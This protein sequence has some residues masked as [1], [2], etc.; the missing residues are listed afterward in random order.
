VLAVNK[1]KLRSVLLSNQAMPFDGL[2]W[3]DPPRT[4]GLP[5]TQTGVQTGGHLWA[6]STAGSAL[7]GLTLNAAAP[8][9]S[10]L[11]FWLG[12]A[13]TPFIVADLLQFD[14]GGQSLLLVSD[15]IT[16]GVAVQNF[17]ASGDLIRAGLLEDS[18][19]RPARLSE[20]ASLTLG[21]QTYLAA[22]AA[23][24]N[25]LHLFEVAPDT[26]RL[27]AV[28]TV[29]DSAKTTLE[30][31]SALLSLRQGAT[32]FLIVASTVE[33][34]LSS[35]ALTAGGG[36]EL[37]DTLGPKDGLWVNGLEDI[38]TISVA[39]QSFVLG[40]SAQSGTLS[41][42]RVNP[43]GAMF[44]TDMVWDSRDTRFAGAQALDVFEA[45]GRSFVVTGG[46][47]DGVSLF[48][49]LPGGQLL[50]HQ[51]LAQGADWAIGH[52]KDIQAMVTGDEVQIVVAAGGGLAQLVLPLAQFGP[53]QQGGGGNDILTGGELDDLLSGG[54]G[55][56]R[57]SGAAGDDHILA[58]TGQDTLTGGAGAD[59]F[60]FTADGASDLITD[61]QIGADRIDL[62][63]WG[64]IYDIS[65][66][67]IRGNALGAVLS[68]Q[69]EV[70]Y[71]HSDDGARLDAGLWG[72]ED[73]LF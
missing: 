30:G 60:V 57:L 52:V 72:P 46:S 73:F 32:E 14:R 34:G 68:W 12:G 43:I 63:G 19:G 37:R 39:G 42:I 53:L 4:G 54:A 48:E 31:I 29:T 11:P 9:Q 70:I 59:V 69:D 5:L 27:T 1:L 24:R 28:E 23:D 64:M 67:T 71:V 62:A 15:A 6:T 22:A 55:N 20:M 7:G 44:L 33:S 45:A 47:D 17:S 26:Q 56:D 58:G 49:L 65:A 3:A 13:E 16:G 61:F 40:V 66:L 10:A 18:T 25:S 38:A 2:W 41:V 51:S 8:L 35:Y 50:H 36:L 21:G